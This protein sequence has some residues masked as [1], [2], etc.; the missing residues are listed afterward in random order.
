VTIE[1]SI[2]WDN[3]VVE[4]GVCITHSIVAN[5]A[6]LLRGSKVSEGCVLSFRVVVGPDVTLP[7]FCKVTTCKDT[8]YG[9]IAEMAIGAQGAGYQ[10][11][12][13][14]PRNNLGICLLASAGYVHSQSVT[15]NAVVELSIEEESDS[16]TEGE[17]E[18]DADVDSDSESAI[19]LVDAEEESTLLFAFVYFLTGEIAQ[20]G[21]PKLLPPF[22]GQ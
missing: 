3:V 10:W 18:T 20:S 2:L 7:R 15:H 16:E 1:S 9:H 14:D 22:G 12:D 19:P 8:P 17:A 5:N 4:D 13:P 11:R 6:K 21:F